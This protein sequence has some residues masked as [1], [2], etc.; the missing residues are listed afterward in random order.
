[1]VAVAMGTAV[2]TGIVA[3][4]ATA[5]TT[6]GGSLRFFIRCLITCGGL[7]PK[8]FLDMPDITGTAT[9]NTTPIT[10]K[11]VEM[12]CAV[13]CWSHSACV[14]HSQPALSKT[15]QI[16]QAALVLHLSLIVRDLHR[17]RTRTCKEPGP[18]RRPGRRP[19]QRI[20]SRL[21]SR[22]RF[23]RSCSVASAPDRFR[24]QT[25]SWLVQARCSHTTASSCSAERYRTQERELEE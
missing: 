17:T 25:A 3:V 22:T 13:F 19:R 18:Q 21:A 2:T 9:K 14:P 4:G 23:G 12:V 5:D 24:R 1:M 8:N 20:G 16:S 11:M 10:N 6:R 7:I 15:Q